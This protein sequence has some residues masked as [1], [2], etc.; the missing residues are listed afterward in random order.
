MESIIK[1]LRLE[2]VNRS[3][4]LNIVENN[5]EIKK[6]R[7]MNELVRKNNEETKNAA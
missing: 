6:I 5:E 2:I 1:I 3:L 7:A 4:S